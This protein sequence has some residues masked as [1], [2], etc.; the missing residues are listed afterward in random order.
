[1]KGAGEAQIRASVPISGKLK[2]RGK[3]GAECGAR[4]EGEAGG[5]DL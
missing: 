3:V 2:P 4:W 1:M 5:S